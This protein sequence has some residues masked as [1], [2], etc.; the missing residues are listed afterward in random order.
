[1][2]VVVVNK[3]SDS[4]NAIFNANETN[5]NNML[6]ENEAIRNQNCEK[7]RYEHLNF[8]KV[9]DLI[10]AGRDDLVDM[11]TGMDDYLFGAE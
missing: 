4:I 6:R 7:V 2:A 9:R 5:V 8:M 1:M 11:I 3:P 10:R